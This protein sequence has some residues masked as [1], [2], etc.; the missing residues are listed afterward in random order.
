VDHSDI[1]LNGYHVPAESLLAAIVES[2]DDAIISK[3]L[4]GIITSWNKGAERVFGYGAEETVGRPVTMLIPDDRQEEE[5][6]ILARLQ[7]GERVEHFET[8][9]KRKD[10]SFLEV[11]LTI[12]PVRNERGVI[13][14][15][16]KIARDITAQKRIENEL[17]R[18]NRDLEQ[19][20]YSASHDLREPLR[21]IGVFSQLLERR[22]GHQLTGEAKEYLQRLNRAATRMD[23]LVHDLL[24]YSQLSRLELRGEECAANEALAGA[25]EGLTA[26]IASEGATVTADDL[27][28]VRIAGTHLQLV[29]QNLIGNAIKYRDPG[30]AATVHVSAKREGDRWVFSVV[31]NGIG[32]EPAFQE[33]IFGLFKRLHNADAYEGTGIGLTIC[34]RIVER[35]DG[36]IWVESQ[37]G[38]G[39][40]FRFT[41]P[42]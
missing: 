13:V 34:Q 25:L 17:R 15:A 18:A 38:A 6:Q 40:A 42:G 27:P 39:S 19:V 30:R 11:S 9:R 12:S 3:N 4:Q 37:P 31:D 23:G 28:P 32:I 33:K 35:Y 21:T 20:A 26:A 1:R 5:P 41:V 7:R 22:Y 14:G 10:G 36:R 29:L 24:T 2:S 16:S 8:V